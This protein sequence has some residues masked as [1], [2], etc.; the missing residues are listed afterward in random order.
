MEFTKVSFVGKNIAQRQRLT[1]PYGLMAFHA[2][3]G[4]A[5]HADVG[6][7]TDSLNDLDVDDRKSSLKRQ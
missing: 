1:A 6:K 4:N 3:S 7:V 5:L 2:D